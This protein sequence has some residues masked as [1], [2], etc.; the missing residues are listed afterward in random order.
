MSSSP[1]GHPNSDLQPS[2]VT[3]R[4]ML[5]GM[6]GLLAL[7]STAACS[8]LST[9]PDKEGG[10]GG[11]RGTGSP[12]GTADAKEAPDLAQRVASGELP[13]VHKRIPDKPLVVEPEG[14]R[15]RYGGTWRTALQGAGDT[16]W[17]GRTIMNEDLTRWNPTATKV[18]PNVAR[19]FDLAPDAQTLTIELYHGMR[20]SDG[21][22][23]TADDVVFSLEDIL[24]N[25][26]LTPVF[27][28]HMGGDHPPSIEKVNTETVRLHFQVPNATIATQIAYRGSGLLDPAHYLKEYH[29][30]YNGDA[31]KVAKKAGYSDW[32]KLF[33]A[34][35]NPISNKDVPVLYPWIVTK[36]VGDGSRVEAK[37][38]PYYWKVDPEGRQ[39]PYLDDVIFD[40]ITNAETILLKA[41]HGDIGFT[42]RHINT[43]TNKPVLARNRRKGDYR[44]VKLKSTYQNEMCIGL[45]LTSEDPALRELFQKKD[46]R[47]GLSYAIDR[48]ELSDTIWQRSGRPWQA[49][50][51][52]ESEYYDEEF[53]H[54]Y[55]EYDTQKAN[56]H[57]DR[58]GLTDVDQEGYRLGLDGQ[59]LSFRVEVAHPALIP[60]WP[61]AMELVSG[62]WKKVG[63]R[64]QIK[65]EDRSLYEE[66]LQAN[67]HDAFVWT[68]PGGLRNETT[69][70]KCYFPSTGGAGAQGWAPLWGQWF[71][72]H[73]SAGTEPPDA[74]KKQIDLYWRFQ[75]EPSEAK[76]KDLYKQI[77]QI[78][79]EQFY[80]IGTIQNP[81]PYGIVKN[82]F[83]NV[84]QGMPAANTFHTPALTNPEQYWV[85]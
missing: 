74:P 47:V 13:S 20:W 41:T 59:P 43:L 68:G 72:S 60:F 77:L 67:K 81:Q 71:L 37:R 30:K 66:R 14:R 10:E 39:L 38:N 55:L 65:N 12:E 32:T 80:V 15:G 6:G 44:F 50:P 78:A 25:D 24:L 3:R 48:S 26:K 69:D 31:D 34:K 19:R 84:P 8:A 58:A 61:D 17:L 85:S 62:Y 18:I 5:T 76:R 45:N 46:F 64:A 52:P 49:A 21:Q 33:L 82:N 4:L 1:N 53:A 11:Q 23:F 27:P 36:A 9:S 7:P 75:K 79:K 56:D 35:Q 51:L 40:V 42:T 83:Q 73:G 2:S 70:T 16:A 28:A 22:P 63:V 54:Q 29:I 57:L